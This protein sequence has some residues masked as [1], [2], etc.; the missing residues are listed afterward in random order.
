MTTLEDFFLSD[1]DHLSEFETETV[2]NDAQKEKEVEEIIVNYNDLSNPQKTQRFVDIMQKVEEVLDSE[3]KLILD[4]N[5]LLVEI[6]KEI[7]MIHTFIRQNYRLKFPDLEFLVTHAIDYARVVKR[8]GNE[9][10]LTLIDLEGL[11]PKNLKDFLEAKTRSVAPNL[12]AIVG[13]KVAA[14]LIVSAGGLSAVANMPS[15]CNVQQL[16]GHKRKKEFVESLDGYLEETEIV[17]NR[18]FEFRSDACELLAEKL[19][20]AARIDFTRGDS[21]GGKG[22]AFRDEILE[23]IGNWQ[24]PKRNCEEG[25]EDEGYET[26]LPRPWTVEFGLEYSFC[27]FGSFSKR[28]RRF[29]WD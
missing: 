4:C 12:S 17:R 22:K 5:K 27:E 14:K 23:E 24:E 15:T 13:S 18:P 7:V 16:V 9:M 26:E 2:K 3:Y 29:D 8:I 28:Q 20:L 19:N 11:L 25:S 21:S 6:D 10:D 1:L